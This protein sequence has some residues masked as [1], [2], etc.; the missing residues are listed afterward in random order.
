MKKLTLLPLLLFITCSP[1]ARAQDAAPA[2]PAAPPAAPA[3]P[4][5]PAKP[6]TKIPHAPLPPNATDAQKNP[7]AYVELLRSNVRQEKRK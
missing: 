7:Q 2:A 3:P 4:A 1:A 6:P 5:P